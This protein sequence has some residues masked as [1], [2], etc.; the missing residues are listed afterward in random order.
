MF[1]VIIINSFNNLIT[2]I[3][4]EVVVEIQTSTLAANKI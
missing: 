3:I 2:I 4:V 1:V